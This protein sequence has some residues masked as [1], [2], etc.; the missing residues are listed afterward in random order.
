MQPGPA[1][2]PSP[3]RYRPVGL[4]RLRLVERCQV[5]VRCASLD[6]LLPPEHP[7]RV[8]WAY[9]EGVDIAPLLQGIKAVKGE[10]GRDANGARVLLGC[11]CSPP[12]L[13]L[14]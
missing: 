8:V 12:Q 14:I 6:Q 4:P 10:V 9:V 2:G 11:G 1:V 7:S 5:E 3:H 13:L